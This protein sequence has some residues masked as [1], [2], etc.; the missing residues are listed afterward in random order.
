MAKKPVVPPASF[1]DDT[2]SHGRGPID[3]DRAVVRSRAEG[4]AAAR[5]LPEGAVDVTAEMMGRTVSI[6]GVPPPKPP[7]DEG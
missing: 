2:Y 1:D 7:K 5:R 4:R 6:V 3:R